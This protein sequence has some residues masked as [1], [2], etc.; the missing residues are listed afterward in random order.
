[1]I[2]FSFLIGYF[3]FKHCIES[4]GL[5]IIRNARGEL[6]AFEVP[7]GG[8]C[9][10]QGTGCPGCALGLNQ[11]G[12]MAG[13]YSDANGV[14]HGFIRG[15]NGAITTFDASGAGMS[16]Y[17]GTGCSSDCS[18]SLNDWGTVAGVYVDTNYVAHGYLR[19]PEGKFATVDP[20]GSVGTYPSGLNDFGGMTGEFIECEQRVPRLS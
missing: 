7:G 14:N 10:Q 17:Q 3:A 8:T 11:S 6:K 15:P 1:M 20:V 2:P 16:I 19:S 5:S 12:A 4:K 18:V 13:T 9:T